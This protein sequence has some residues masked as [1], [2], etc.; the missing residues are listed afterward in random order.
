MARHPVLRT[1]FDL[2]GY[3]EPLQLVHRII[4]LPLKTDDL[5]DL[6]AADQEQTLEQWFEAE[7]RHQF[8]WKEAPLLRFHIHQRDEESFQFSFTEH[9][10]ILDGWSVASMLTELFQDYSSLLNGVSHSITSPAV[11]YR[12]FV[13]L[14]RQALASG[15]FK[16]YWDE[17]LHNSTVTELPRW[18]SLR[19]G[20][21]ERKGS[22]HEV[23]LTYQ[24]D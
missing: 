22:T 5:R 6:T 14:E 15:D 20:G 24:K 2:T 19:Q 16:R 13:S 8:A 11:R 17:K 1:S 9:H 12:D 10:A 3:S 18:S 23:I 21:H 4:D 7:K